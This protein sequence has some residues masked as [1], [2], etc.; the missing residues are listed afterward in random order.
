[1]EAAAEML[2][3]LP[4]SHRY[5]FTILVELPIFLF[6]GIWKHFNVVCLLGYASLSTNFK[7]FWLDYFVVN[8]IIYLG[9]YYN[10]LTSWIFIW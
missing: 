2:V 10:I 4:S 7:F 6:M 3:L 8:S 5:G 1:M 9:S